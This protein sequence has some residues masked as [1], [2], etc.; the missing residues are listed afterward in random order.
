VKIFTIIKFLETNRYRLILVINLIFLGTLTFISYSQDLYDFEHSRKY[1]EYL[2]SSHQYTLAAEEYERM[3][4][5]DKSNLSFKYN[6]I[7]NYR[8]SGDLNSGIK[9]IY[10]LYGN[11]PDTLPSI[12][13]KEFMKLQ[14]LSDSLSVVENFITRG[15]KLS[16]ENKTIINCCNLLLKGNYK[17][18]GVLA[19]DASA[20]YSTFPPNIYKLTQQAGNIKFKSR[21]IAG[22]FSAVI[23][24]TG[25]FYTKNWADGVVSILFV[26]G[27]AWQAYRGFNE[28]GSK[29]VYG[30]TFATISA[31][32]YIGNIFGSVKAASR[33]NDNKKY[34][35]DNQIFDFV[36]SDS[37]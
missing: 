2:S 12:L 8:L 7:K 13:A 5:F 25:K 10:S 20:V 17:Q 31:S 9:R 35:I 23:P 6:L 21:Y 29:S 15:N 24:G 22:S 30:W 14:L 11:L 28:H 36:N 26:A 1:A 37:F 32:F 33:Y 34:E 18:A 4:F 27:S 3:V 19:K 16:E